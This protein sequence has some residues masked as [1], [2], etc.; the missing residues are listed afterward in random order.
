MNGIPTLDRG[1]IEAVARRFKSAWESGPRPR[2]EDFLAEVDE[3]YWPLLLPEL[4]RLESDLR[5]LGGEETSAEEYGRRFPWG[6]AAVDRVF[7][8]EP[9]PAGDAD[10]VSETTAG[11]SGAGIGSRAAHGHP[12]ELAGHPDYEILR[13][14]GRGGMGVVYL[15]HNH[16]MGRDEVLKVIGEE[17][18]NKPGV[19]DRFL[20]EIRAVA[21]L[22]HPNI[23]S[24][25]TAFRAGGRLVFSMEYVDGLD[26]RRVVRARGPLPVAHACN[27]A[28]LAARGLQHAY[29]QGMVHRDI[30]PSNLMLS[31]DAGRAVIKLLDFGLA[32]ATREQSGFELIVPEPVHV[33]DLGDTLTRAGQMLGTPDFIAPEQIVDAQQADIRADIYSLGCTLY[34]LLS[35]KPPFQASMLSNV[36]EAH[37][38]VN[39][40][41]LDRVRGDVPA[42]LAALVTRMLAKDPSHRFQRPVDVAEALAP[43]F[44]QRIVPLE[45]KGRGTSP[46]TE[47]TAHRRA[48]ERRHAGFS[49]E[50]GGPVDVPAG[51]KP[52]TPRAVVG[53]TTGERSHES[54]LLPPPSPALAAPPRAEVLPGHGERRPFYHSPLA[55][56]GIVLAVVAV[57]G[58]GF[59]GW[60]LGRTTTVGETSVMVTAKTDSTATDRTS[61]AAAPAPSSKDVPIKATPPVPAAAVPVRLRRAQAP[62][63]MTLDDMAVSVERALLGPVAGQPEGD[64]LSLRLRIT[65]LSHK[66]MRHQPW[67][68]PGT[69]IILCDQNGAY[70]NLLT[71]PVARETSINP[72]T[73][74][75]ETL[76]FDA[77]PPGS[78]LNLDLPIAGGTN[79]FLFHILPPGPA[80]SIAPPAAVSPAKVAGATGEQKSSSIP[81]PVDPEKDPKLRATLV[82]EYNAGER[83]IEVRA[84]GRSANEGARLRR[85]AAKELVKKL[86]EKH[87][88]SEDKV[89]RIVGLD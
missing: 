30:K 53:A 21:K 56:G 58:C 29:E 12:A 79:A 34:C 9:A 28:A 10:R 76:V 17:I 89:R 42:E 82:S 87:G 31:H 69:A 44:K 81:A 38:L 65:N 25:Y 11:D 50:P 16:L 6:T 67:P 15:A 66:P 22:R 3:S 78:S 45:I 2:I 13:E 32:K 1:A 85:N 20:R 23:V 70:Y 54:K 33:G 71:A 55:L 49:L 88:I 61:R 5:R 40:I 74:I 63:P 60:Y 14:L 62:A 37:K 48:V 52:S 4:I 19:L 41:P 35:G 46:L 57:L 59:I 24:A 8:A 77:P 7:G 26:L 86:A 18:I 68:Q 80:P 72:N 84:R 36:L 75:V 73:T 39:A 83:H 51:V 43:F 47:K 27:F 64:Y